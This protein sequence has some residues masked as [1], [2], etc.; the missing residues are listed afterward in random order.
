LA[1]FPYEIIPKPGSTNK[2]N[3][4][5]RCPDYKEGIAI[6]N[7]ERVL[8][9]P[10]KFCIQALQT[11]VTNSLLDKAVRSDGSFELEVTVPQEE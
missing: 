3:V 4:L 6:D 1:T 5:S 8:L 7:A 10:D 11:T 2:A 9:I